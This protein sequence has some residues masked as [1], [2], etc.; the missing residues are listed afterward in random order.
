MD[1]PSSETPA[2]RIDP[3][4][5]PPLPVVE[6]RLDVGRR[7]VVTGTVRIERRVERREVLVD[8]PLRRESVGIERVP[9]GRVLADDEHPAPRHDGDTLVVPVVEEELVVVRRRV[10]RE[11]LRV[12]RTIETHRAPQR[13]EVFAE[14]VTVRRFDAAGRPVPDDADTGEAAPRDDTSTTQPEPRGD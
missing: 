5:V 13:V 14:R 6:E 3:E 9:L 2:H 1:I 4:P 8:E 10:L 11:E 7:T 12:R